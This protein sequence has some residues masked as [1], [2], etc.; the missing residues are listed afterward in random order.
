M[1][2]F[3]PTQVFRDCT[4]VVEEYTDFVISNG[5]FST[6]VSGTGA[7]ASHTNANMSDTGGT[8]GWAVLSAGT[9]NS[10][11][12]AYGTFTTPGVCFGSGAW[13]AECLMRIPTLSDGTDTFCLVMGFGD[14]LGAQNGGTDAIAF[15]YS[16]GTNSGKFECVTRSNGTET[17]SDSGITVATDTNYRLRIEINAAGTSVAFYING[18]LTATNTTNIPT[19]TARKANPM[20]NLLKLAGTNNRECYLDYIYLRCDL[21]AAR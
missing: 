3:A 5:G 18:T 17:A 21:T 9:T 7:A 16:H 10:G 1:Q 20:F 12:A 14:N 8:P 6:A 4:R 2:L 15:R 11:R 19:G 13:V